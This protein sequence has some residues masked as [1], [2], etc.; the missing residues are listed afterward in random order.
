MTHVLYA[1]ADNDGDVL[2]QGPAVRAVAA[3][4]DRVT[5]LCGPRGARAA[6][7]LPGIDEVRVHHL[8]WIDAEPQPIDRQ[9]TNALVDELQALGADQAFVS[10]SFHQS[11]LPLALLLRMAGVSTI[12]AI[13]IDYPGSLLDV[14]AA[15][16]GDVHEV[17][18]ALHLV[19][20]LGYALPASDD[21]AL[22]ITRTAEPPAGLPSDYVVVH[23]GAS[24]PARAWAPDRSRALVR[25]LAEQ[26]RDVVVTGAPSERELTRYVGDG[27]AHDLGGRT[28]LA[29]LAA[30]LAG[31]QVAVVG[32]TGPAHLAAAVRTPVVSLFA[33]TVP[34]ARWRPWSVPHELLY[35]DVPCAGCRARICPIPDQPCLH[36]VSVDEVLRA[37]DRLA[38][39]TA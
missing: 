32:N 25:A 33:P 20:T 4:A 5:L 39:V 29:E 38:L 16:P 31:A 28:D 6:R 17:E 9:R 19:S 8:P 27:L 13:S 12:A 2:L 37:V 24:A 22:A 18:R 14:R 26:G 36:D 3:Q 30:T 11:P 1:R 10:T 34:P 21:G 15:D 23:P 7:L 35:R